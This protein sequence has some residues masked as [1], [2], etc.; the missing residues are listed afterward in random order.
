MSYIEFYKRENGSQPIKEYLDSLDRKQRE[1]TLNKIDL[2]KERGNWLREPDSKHLGDGIFELRIQ[3]GS[4]RGRVLY[5]FVSE[6]RIVLTHGF[7]KRT[8]K[9]PRREIA[10]AKSYRNDYM[11]YSKGDN[12]ER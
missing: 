12:D 2:L 6:G 3:Q 9:T 8:K 1:K 10:A 5:F 11:A 4:D 7:M